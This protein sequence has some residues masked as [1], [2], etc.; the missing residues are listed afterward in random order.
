MEVTEQSERPRDLSPGESDAVTIA[1]ADL[2]AAVCGIARVGVAL[3]D[4]GPRA[5]G[6]GMLFA[7]GEPVTVRGGTAVP[8]PGDLSWAGA[9]AAGVET[10][11]LEPL[12][13][14]SVLFGSEDGRSGFDLEL[15]ARSEPA[16]LD[17]RSPA[18]RLGGM[19]GYDQLVAVSGTVTV[20][21]ADRPFRGLGQR[22]R[23]WGSPDW[24]RLSM[25]RTIGVW[26]EDGTGVTIS[27]LRPAGDRGLRDEVAAATLLPGPDA[28]PLPVADPRI[29][30]IYDEDGRQQAAGLE[31]W[32]GED[33]EE[34]IR[35]AGDVACG[36]TLD[37]GAL[38]LDAAFFTWS[39]G[40]RRGVGRYDCVLRG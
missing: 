22:G 5:S 26:L 16:T 40:A 19:A 39:D 20:D 10:E 28:D 31:L 14:W 2:N 11:V 37:L 8:A 6:L 27:A 13:R 29:S 7:G 23:S 1:F 38:R 4:E 32:V 34:A 3:T 35:L 30:T 17:A 25:A 36:T 9:A 12:R 21:G 33:D 15:E 24:D 18:G